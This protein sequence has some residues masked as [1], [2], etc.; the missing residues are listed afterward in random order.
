M[1]FFSQMSES[2]DIMS[3]ETFAL[4]SKAATMG[5]VVSAAAREQGTSIVPMA[6]SW[7]ENTKSLEEGKVDVKRW[8][9][10]AALSATH[11]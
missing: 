1:N 2:D 9:F 5:L 11:F 10:N 6:S 7:A 4:A 3:M 8:R